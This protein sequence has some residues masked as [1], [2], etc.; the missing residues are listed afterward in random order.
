M[1]ES[2]VRQWYEALEGHEVSALENGAFALTVGVVELHVGPQVGTSV[3]VGAMV[4]EDT[5]EYVH[6]SALEAFEGVVRHAEAVDGMLTFGFQLDKGRIF[7]TRGVEVSFHGTTR[8]SFGFPGGEVVLTA[9]QN[10]TAEIFVDGAFV[11]SEVVENWAD[12]G[13]VVTSV[14]SSL[15]RADLEAYLLGR[16]LVSW[17]R[18]E[19]DG[20]SYGL[21]GLVLTDTPEGPVHRFEYWEAAPP[22]PEVARCEEH[23]GPGA[24][25]WIAGQKVLE[26]EIAALAG[27]LAAE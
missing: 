9:G 7:D 11:D 1:G 27:G 18:S 20:A 23:V 21:D 25:V 19:G 22:R 3:R 5:W 14:Y 2:I 24:V 16:E 15:P 13:G 4:V 26:G 10:I 17:V 6:L 8:A 12:V